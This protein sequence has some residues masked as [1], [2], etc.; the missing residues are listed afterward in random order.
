[1]KP[2]L[3]LALILLASSCGMQ[4]KTTAASLKKQRALAANTG[5]NQLAVGVT[6]RSQSFLYRYGQ[7]AP[8]FSTADTTSNTN[9]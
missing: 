8:L 4:H 1:M 6:L 9:Q 2:L 3:S 5:D 7:Y